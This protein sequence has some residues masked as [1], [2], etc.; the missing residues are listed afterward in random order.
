MNFLGIR[1]EN[2]RVVVSSKDVARV[3]E[4]NHGHVLRDIRELKCSPEFSQ[5]NFGMVEFVDSKGEMRPEY[6]MTKDGCSILVMGY[7]GKK[8]MQF[9]EAY[10]SEFNKMEKELRERSA[11]SAPRSLKEALLLAAKLEEE[12]EEMEARNKVMLPKAEFYDAVTGS[13]T[14]IDIGRVAKVLNFKGIGRNN[15]FAFLR[16]SNILMEGNLP[17]QDF[18]DRGYFR[19]IEQKYNT[20]DGETHISFKTVVYQTGV[21]FIRRKLLQ[22]GYMASEEKAIAIIDFAAKAV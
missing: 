7:N 5:T 10:I 2:N 11:T 1:V 6:L 15:L 18:I 17:Y 22:A 9:K 21:D 16:D 20:P 14:A 13:A 4:K 12:R 19:V 3:F 8:A